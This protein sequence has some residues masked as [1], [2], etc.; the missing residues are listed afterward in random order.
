MDMPS[1]TRFI[2]DKSRP[3]GWRP[4]RVELSAPRSALTLE[5]DPTRPGK[6]QPVAK[7]SAFADV[8]AWL[9][10][11]CSKFTARARRPDPFIEAFNAGVEAWGSDLTRWPL[12]ELLALCDV[13]HKAAPRSRIAACLV[14][15]H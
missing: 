12:D 10:A 5:S 3:S 13:A 4:E 15:V 6:L 2:A 7:P 9:G 11:A 14:R 8:R 1:F